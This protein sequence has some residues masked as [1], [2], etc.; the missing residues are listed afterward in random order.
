MTKNYGN[1]VSLRIRNSTTVYRSYLKFTPSG[2]LGPVKS[3][4]LRLWV[5]DASPDGG[6]VYA[7]GSTWTA[8]KEAYYGEFSEKL[9]L[10]DYD[11]L[12]QYPQRSLQLIYT[13][14]DEPAFE[15]DFD[16]VDYEE[17]EFD[18]ALGVKDLHTVRRKV[19]F[20]SRRSVL[21]PELYQK[22][23]EMDFWQDNTGTAA[24]YIGNKSN[25]QKD[26]TAT[27]DNSGSTT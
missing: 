13:F 26:A 2:L 5:N 9:L 27:P 4:T 10:I 20:K 24:C 14:L 12:T 11:L 18:Q 17:G 21:P 6:S 1:D 15:H 7:V 19:E 22:Y 25:N 23:S 16:N 8:L 3:A